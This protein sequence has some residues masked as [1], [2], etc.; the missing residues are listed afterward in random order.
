MKTQLPCFCTAANG[1]S[2]AATCDADRYTGSIA[3]KTMAAWPIVDSSIGDL[4]SVGA[5]AFGGKNQVFQG[6]GAWVI[7]L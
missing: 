1:H 6:L 2:P 7:F 5:L 4:E 3:G